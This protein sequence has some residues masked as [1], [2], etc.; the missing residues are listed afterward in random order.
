[1]TLDWLEALAHAATV[2]AVLFL[3]PQLIGARAAKQRDFEKL[4]VQRYWNFDG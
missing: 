4:Y 3:V 1:M 2:V